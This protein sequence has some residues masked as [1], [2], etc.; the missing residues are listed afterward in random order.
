MPSNWGAHHVRRERLDRSGRGYRGIH[1]G[2]RRR[3]PGN[4]AA[5]N[6]STLSTAIGIDPELIRTG[7]SGRKLT[8]Y[9]GDPGADKLQG[10]FHFVVFELGLKRTT[11]S[12]IRNGVVTCTRPSGG[13]T[14]RWKRLISLPKTVTRLPS[15]S[16]TCGV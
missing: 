9:I 13:Y 15:T 3:T 6:Y 10:R 2:L 11:S 1:L 12:S 7:S 14:R 4:G 5:G 16:T 8:V